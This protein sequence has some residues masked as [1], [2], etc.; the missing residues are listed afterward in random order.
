M[1]TPNEFVCSASEVD[2]FKDIGDVQVL[3]LVVAVFLCFQYMFE[4]YMPSR[5]HLASIGG[6]IK[7]FT[8][9]W[10]SAIIGDPLKMTRR[11]NIGFRASD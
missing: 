5:T 7:A 3:P 2:F 11:S 9:V 10:R 1:I 8:R 6:N 4:W